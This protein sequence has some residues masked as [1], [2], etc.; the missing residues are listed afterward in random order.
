MLGLG[1]PEREELLASG[2]LKHFKRGDIIRQPYERVR[3]LVFP[4]T[5]LASLLLTMADGRVAEVGALG[6]EG[7]VGFQA[8]LGRGDMPSATVCVVAGHGY[9][10]PVDRFRQVVGRGRTR[11]AVAAYAQALLTEITQLVAC[12]RFHDVEQRVARWL[13]FSH[14]RLG[15]DEFHMTQEYLATMV[16]ASRTAVSLVGSR[17]AE[18]RM[19]EFRHGTVRIVDRGALE[20]S[21]CE[22]YAVIRSE[23]TRL[24]GW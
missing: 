12:N 6:R 19:V 16:G 2:V 9:V 17:L 20:G 8:L 5:M 14:D 3:L 23:F 10:I 22:C 13:L 4:E 7:V 15:S 18:L 21:S 24:L 11:Q 1:Q